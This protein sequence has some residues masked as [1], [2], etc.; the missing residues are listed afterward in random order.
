MTPTGDRVLAYA[1]D[2]DFVVEGIRDPATGEFYITALFHRVAAPHVDAE[3]S[4]APTML[5]VG[6]EAEK[7]INYVETWLAGRRH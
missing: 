2:R 6:A 3:A 4:D 1:P 7:T 5:L